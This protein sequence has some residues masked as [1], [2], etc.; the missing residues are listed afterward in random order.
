[1]VL[2][3]RLKEFQNNKMFF[4]FLNVWE[5]NI[6]MKQ[7]QTYIYREKICSCLRREDWGGKG[8]EFGIS[9]CNIKR[10]NNKV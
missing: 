7:K 9:R 3:S 5:M 2:E 4:T 8:W 1:M 6:P 10:L